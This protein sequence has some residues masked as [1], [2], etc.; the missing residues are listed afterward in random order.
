VRVG[1]KREL[2]NVG[3]D[4]AGFLDVRAC[5]GS[6]TI[7]GRTE[8]TWWVHGV[9][10]QVRRGERVTALTGGPAAYIY[11]ERERAGAHTKVAAPTDRPHRS[12][13]EGV[14]VRACEAGPN[15]PKG[16]AGASCGL[17]WLLFLN[18]NF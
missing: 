18:L 11:R 16:R 9:V 13:R 8:L 12:K 10:T 1:L 2:E 14:D 3:H 17:L 15:G 7:V 5:R 4:M 6:A